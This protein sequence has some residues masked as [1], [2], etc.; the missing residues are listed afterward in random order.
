M[1]RGRLQGELFELLSPAPAIEYLGPRA[2]PRSSL[3]QGI[4]NSRHL[5][6][7]RRYLGKRLLGQV[8][9]RV[10]RRRIPLHLD[11]LRRRCRCNR[12]HSERR[13]CIFGRRGSQR[14]RW[15]RL[16][17]VGEVHGRAPS[18]QGPCS[19]PSQLLELLLLRPFAQR[20]T[21]LVVPVHELALELFRRDVGLLLDRNEVVG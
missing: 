19:E 10:Q 17:T 4:W 6:P 13:P 5:L 15:L 1:W 2:I 14:E 9:I 7:L 12:L 18:F 11:R 3:I 21:R 8:F 20:S 16:I